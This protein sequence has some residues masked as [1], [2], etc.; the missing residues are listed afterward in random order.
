M[1]THPSDD[2]SEQQ[3]A[4]E[5]VR[6]LAQAVEQSP[7]SIVVT[8]LEANIVY[9]NRAFSERSGYSAA[10]VIGENPRILQSALTPRIIYDTLWRTLLKG[11]TW[12]GL[13]TNKRKNGEVYYEHALV[14]PIRLPDGQ[15][16]HYLAVK[17]D[18]T[19]SKR[20]GEELD[21]YRYHLE[22]QV[23]LR[24]RELEEAKL[25]SEVANQAK[26]S[27][28]AN[29]SHEIRTPMN[30]ILGLSH[31]LQNEIKDVEQRDKITKIRSSADHLLSVINN[32][33]DIPK[34][35]A[36]KLVLDSV[37]FDLHALLERALGLIRERAEAKGLTLEL[38]ADPLHGL[39]LRGD[40]TRL[41]QALLNFLSNAVKFTDRGRISLRGRVLDDQPES[42]KLRFEVSDTGIG[43]AK[44]VI[45][46]LFGAF[47]QADNSIS[48]NYGGTGL[49]LAI[50]R[51][52]A[53][54]MGGSTGVDSTPGEGSTFWMEIVF[55]KGAPI[56][57]SDDPRPLPSGVSVVE[58]L[59]RVTSQRR[60][61]LCEDNP[62]N[63][64]VGIALLQDVGLQ[65]SVADNGAEG[66]ALIQTTPVDLVLMD[67]QMPVMGELEATRRIRELP[68]FAS[69]PIL[70]M[71]A[72]AFADDRN[73]CLNA[74]MNDFVA[75]PV[76][77]ELLYEALLK[78]L[79]VQEQERVASEPETPPQ[80][81]S[82][83][84]LALSQVPGINLH[85]GLKITKG[86]ARRYLELLVMFCA[87]H[88]GDIDQV[89]VLLIDGRRSAAE[90]VAHSLTGASS[91]LQLVDIY[92]RAK[93]LNQM[94]RQK[95]SLDE[96]FLAIPDLESALLD[97]QAAIARI[98][99]ECG[100]D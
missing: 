16:T 6:K 53:E 99:A 91:N 35:E 68:G 66:L 63:Q 26:S 81:G 7:E 93:A 40:A 69:L 65:V 90:H 67:M 8:D 28:L 22:E 47:E 54:M 5:E 82:D 38:D 24:T 94:I 58:R 80:L 100:E 50:T 86:N 46:R 75:K 29:M 32:I 88:Q 89:R 52:V 55:P 57:A 11:E 36:G 15:I 51:R 97:L 1:S 78:W 17:Q 23:Q 84:M 25:E 4:L 64:E 83:V 49:G 27:F 87:H 73:N 37:D 96:V 56:K 95:L 31:L 18:I 70:A 74:G 3:K 61:L 14:S 2:I 34:I 13:F 48:R 20:M 9:V 10:E 21:R 85:A 60:V 30:A 62:I 44:P 12:S 79:P 43:I 42:V 71:T 59:R 77:P 72:N 45:D 98:A 33:L 76:E 92:Q 19:E 41:T 39:Q